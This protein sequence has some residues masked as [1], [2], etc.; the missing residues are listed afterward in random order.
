MAAK[1]H[2]PLEDPGIFD[3]MTDSR[4]GPR[5]AQD[6]PGASWMARWLGP[7]KRFRNQYEKASTGQKIGRFEHY[8][9]SVEAN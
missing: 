6:E 7:G 9:Q 5:N 2:F 4:V 8:I 1:C 3:E